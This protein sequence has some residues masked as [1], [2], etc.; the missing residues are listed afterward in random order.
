MNGKRIPLSQGRLL[1]GSSALNG[2]AFVA[3]SKF[4]VD[5]WEKFGNPGWNWQSLSSYF[6]KSCTLTKP[7]DAACTHLGLDYVNETTSANFKG[8]IQ[9]SFAEEV[10]NPLPKAWV[11]SFN[12][13]GYT[14]SGDPF[15]G[16]AVG[17]YVN[18]MNIHPVT[19]Q[20]SHAGNAYYEPARARTNLTIVTSAVVEESFSNA[21]RRMLLLKA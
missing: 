5:A 4:S 12:N 17:G 3:P 8:P 16:E 14:V 11:E 2:L 9:A 7:S 20:R 13:L 1:G 15:T 19:K 6:Q 18:A 21:K 10:S